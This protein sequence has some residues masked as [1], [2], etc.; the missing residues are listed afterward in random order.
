MRAGDK[1]MQERHMAPCAGS[2]PCCSE[3]AEGVVYT[4]KT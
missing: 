3:G 2:L 1:G 4:R